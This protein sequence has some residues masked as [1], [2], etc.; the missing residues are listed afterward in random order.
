[1]ST[2][3]SEEIQYA[4]RAA[5][6]AA[7]RAPSVHNTQP[8]SFGT[9]GE[10]II[11]RGDAERMLPTGDPAGRE[12]LISCGAAL[13]NL[14]LTALALGYRPVT[15]VLPDPDRPSVLATV[16]LGDAVGRD[17]HIMLLH[18]EIERR[19]THRADFA[20]LELPRPFV[21][22]LSREAAAEGARL[23][24]VR[25]EPAVRTL[26]A[27]TRAAQEVQAQDTAFS[28]ELLRWSRAPE[29]TRPD[30]VPAGAYPAR[31]AGAPAEDF[32]RRDYARGR[33][34][35]Y[36]RDSVGAA[37]DSPGVVTLLT[38]PGDSRENWI[39]AGCGLQRALLFASAYGV[40]AAFHTQPLEFFHLREFI[41]QEL[42]SGE[43][44]QMIVRF[45]VTPDRP[46]TPRRPLTEVFPLD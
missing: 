4:V 17:E 38:T 37:D 45:G 12:L 36:R 46:A 33:P 20:D 40:S 44:P 5:V 18:A 31:P 34:W 29:S 42:C 14:R 35:G 27:L 24:P 15:R 39:T 13:C 32:A 21:D 1:M 41:R 2:R 22:A 16:R 9:Q 19:H 26:A 28:L 3:T 7:V 6:E 11:L 23:T 30:G 43:P 25:A 10:E 8:W